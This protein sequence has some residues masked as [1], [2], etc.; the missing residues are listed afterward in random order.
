[1][2]DIAPISFFCLKNNVMVGQ[3]EVL[4]WRQNHVVEDFQS[5]R[6]RGEADREAGQHCGAERKDE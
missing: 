1:M 3:L 4:D 2:S 6:H 5:K